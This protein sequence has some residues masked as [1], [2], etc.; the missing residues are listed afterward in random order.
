MTQPSWHPYDPGD[1]SD[2][3]F[4]NDCS[5]LV[6]LATPAAREA[7]WA[8]RTAVSLARGWAE[9]G[10][11]VFLADLALSRPRLHAAFGEANGEGMSDV[12]IYGASLK[13]IARAVPEGFLYAPTGTPVLDSAVALSSSRWGLLADG[14]ARAGAQLVAFLPLDEP[15]RDG[16]LAHA[17]RIVVLTGADG[18]R[19]LPAGV[20]AER[21]SRVL[22]PPRREPAR[23]APW[24]S[25]PAA[26][27]R[28]APKG[29]ARPK[30]AA[31]PQTPVAWAPGPTDMKASAPAPRAAAQVSP[32]PPFEEPERKSRSGLMAVGLLLALVLVAVI[33]A[34]TGVIQIPGISP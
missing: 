28:A 3:A 24:E 30:G 13:R 2:V 31:L 18:A 14:F 8:E 23:S 22:S 5:L 1:P 11:R 32:E 34:V 29:A 20:D 17:R 16:V 4:E 26:G 27:H 12:L 19:A 7:E 6:L 9:S 10:R 15:G 21:V 25:G 33:L